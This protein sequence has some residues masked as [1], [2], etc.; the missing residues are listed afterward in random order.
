MYETLNQLA[1]GS[2]M[3]LR[4]QILFLKSIMSFESDVV[5]SERSI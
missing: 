4:N 3:M 5:V 1:S 2:H